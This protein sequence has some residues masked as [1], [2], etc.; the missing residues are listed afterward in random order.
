M[1]YFIIGVVSLL[2]CVGFFLA[3]VSFAVRLIN[4]AVSRDE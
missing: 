1:N 3:G 2:V 4:K